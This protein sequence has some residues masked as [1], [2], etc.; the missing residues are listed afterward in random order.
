MRNLKLAFRTLFK[1]PF[2]TSIAILSLALGIGANAA[3]YSLFDQILRRPLPVH[4]PDRLV[5]LAAPGPKPGSTSCNQSGD[6]DAVFSYPMFRDLEAAE[7]ALSGLAAHRVFGANVAYENQTLNG[8]GVMV[9]GS[10]FPLLGIQPARGRLLGP[11]DDETIGAHY[12]A[13]LGHSYWETRLGAD[14]DAVGRTIIIN[15]HP[16]TI[17]G[18]APPGFEGTTFGA[19]PLV[20]VP[21]TMRGVLNPGFEGFENRRVYWTYVFG[22]MKPGVSLEQAAASLNT[23]YGPIINDVE[24]ALQTGM[25]DQTLTRFRAKR[26][27]VEDG[28]RG[29]SSWHREARVPLMLLL[30][31]T[32]IVLLIACAN[33]A[34]LLLARGANR[35]LE[36][37]VRLSIGAGR[38][39]V[40]GQLL[41]ESVV[42]ALLGGLAS[43]LVARWTM[44]GIAAIIPAE[45]VSVLQLELSL[46]VLFFT[47][48]LSLVTGLLFGL[49][50]AL[51]STRPDLISTLRG[52]A[53]NL[54]GTRFAARFRTALVTT[55]IALSM[56]LLVTAGLFIRSL[57]NVGRVDLG[58]RVEDI[59][60]FAVSPVL[61]GYDSDRS[62][63]FFERLEEE[64]AAL[65]GVTSVTAAMVPVLAG[66]NWGSSVA[67]EGFERG[68][69]TDVHSNFNAV[70]AG[71]FSTLGVSLLAGREFT[72]SDNADGASVAIVNEAFAEKFGLGRDAVGKR[73]AVG[74]DTELDIEII[75]LIRNAKY[76]QVKDEVPPVFYRP[77]RQY[78]Q[79]G[80]MSFYVHATID[81]AQVMR[82]IPPVVARLDPNLPIQGLSTMT[83]VVQDN[84]FVD[85]M[86]GTLSSTFAALATL[87]AAVGLYGVLAYTVALRTREIGV[88]MALGADPANVRRLVF[89]QVATMLGIGGTIGLL[90]A[91]G[92]G[93]AARSLLFELQGAD[94]IAM[95]AAV[96]LLTI[97]AL[98]AGFVPAY[99]AARV[100]PVR[101]LRYE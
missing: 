89:R 88:R 93:R 40:V 23:V 47:G 95:A 65:P 83:R 18:I 2:V 15:G 56:A 61:N 74:G 11:A 43:L 29:Q 28:R 94:P 49:F 31:T 41:I 46:P 30:A 44:A 12:V 98:A 45:A 76:S 14:P 37:A 4:E 33:I 17:V 70:G 26:I 67:V 68:P 73:M 53:G 92:L 35:G 20:Y 9:S 101:A 48:A 10:Y 32:G 81:P 27:E 50:P 82:A 34:N 71:F 5:N 99:R 57:D 3:I 97:F 42:L 90:G 36:M 96:V 6:C 21:I 60:T 55:Q 51:H 7:T 8:E 86:I 80:A 84:V 64:L 75:G 85:R 38:R 58:M 69:D 16:F 63:L 1:S 25:S 100:D 72:V 24:A 59:V 54:T 91:W 87:L 39:H 66:S 78:P 22:R 13:V 79:V 77:W 19:H 62:K 52:S